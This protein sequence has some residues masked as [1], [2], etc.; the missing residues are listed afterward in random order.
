[1][2]EIRNIVKDNPI[3][4]ILRNVPPEKTI[5]YAAAIVAGGVRFFEV[6]MNSPEACMQIQMLREYF[7]KNEDIFIGAGTAITLERVKAAMDAGAQFL[8]TPS[9]DR[10]VVLYCEENHIPLMPGVMT[11]TDASFCL[12]HGFNTLKLFP[13]G[14][15]PA[16]YVKSLKGPLDDTE[17]V[18]IGG[19]SPDNIAQFFDRGFIGVGLASA[20]MPKQYVADERWDD[21]S[22]YVADLLRRV[23]ETLV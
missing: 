19:V 15:L 9:S 3:L 23:K 11:P 21:G 4:A 2:I 6:A 22:A 18:A 12:Q 13:A 8:L 16:G 17:Y 5:P 10:D 7:A 1:M 20:I 14:D